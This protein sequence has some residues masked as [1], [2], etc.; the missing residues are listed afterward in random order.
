[1]PS[2]LVEFGEHALKL[3]VVED[4]GVIALDI[5]KALTLL[6][7][8]VTDVAGSSEE[9]V[10]AADKNTPDVVLMDIHLK[11]NEDG[12]TAASRIRAKHDVAIIFLTAH[13]D[14]D[15]INRVKAVDP[16]GYLI[17]PFTSASLNVTIE[18]AL[19]RKKTGRAQAET[20]RT[21]TALNDRLTRLSYS[22]SHDLKEPLRSVSAASDLLA[23][24]GSEFDPDAQEYLEWIKDGCHRM[25]HLLSS[26][27]QYYKDDSGMPA[28]PRLISAGECLQTALSHLK[29]SLAQ[30]EADVQY[31]PLPDVM[32]HPVAMV[33]IF[34]NI[35]ANSLK[36][37]SHRAP[38]IYISAHPEREFWTFAITDNGIGFSPSKAESIF[39]FFGRAHGKDHSGSGIG[40]AL[41]R[42]LVE[43]YGGS[44]WAESS[45]GYGSTFFF[46]LPAAVTVSLPAQPPAA[47][48]LEYRTR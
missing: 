12:I 35:I 41:C 19:Q 30:A 6:G 20:N 47:L 31:H 2:P 15:T 40:L 21:L 10:R 11:G 27:L 42:R 26:L 36:Y 1:M 29:G 37:R 5:R 17:K 38:E 48:P 9:A 8:T 4:E 25:D 39:D 3:L 28:E 44:I 16:Y 23:R 24:S 13:S 22:L 32:C 33:Q 43:H 45:V 46:T 18:M 34:Q 14:R 7:H